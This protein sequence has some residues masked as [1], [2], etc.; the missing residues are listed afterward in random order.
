[1]LMKNS[2][3]TISRE[4]E[5]MFGAFRTSPII[6][7]GYVWKVAPRMSGPQKYRLRNRMKRVDEN[8]EVLY[9]SLKLKDQESTGYRKI[10]YLKHNFP[11]E[12]ELSSRDKYTTFDKKA[13]D[14]R[15]SLH[16]VP[17]WT[18]LSF[19]ENPKYY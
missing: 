5:N 16:R 2:I 11:K 15:K 7:G 1:M 18:K 17:K 14:Y 19:R 12:H 13:K 3:R 8:I 9:Q 10:D 6:S 4:D